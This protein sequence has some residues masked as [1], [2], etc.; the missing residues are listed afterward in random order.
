M[1]KLSLKAKARTNQY[2]IVIVWLLVVSDSEIGVSA[3]DGVTRNTEVP[4]DV[5]FPLVSFS[6][7]TNF[8]K[9]VLDVSGSNA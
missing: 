8:S 6:T 1:T 3:P 4:V 2:E 5:V 7:I 9:A